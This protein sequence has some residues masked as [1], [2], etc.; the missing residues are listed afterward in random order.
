VA[1]IGQ[2]YAGCGSLV[3]TQPSNQTQNILSS[4][5][6]NTNAVNNSTFQWQMNDGSN[7]TNLSNGGQYSGVTSSQLSI[8]SLT[9]AND[10]SEFRCLITN[11]ACLD[12]T[13]V[14]TLTVECTNLIGSDPSSGV[15]YTN[16]TAQM[17]VAAANAG[18][19]FQWQNFSSGAWTNLSNG[20]QYSGVTTNTLSIANLTMANNGDSYRCVLAQAGCSDTSAAAPLTVI[21]D[22]GIEEEGVNAM[23]IYPIPAKDYFTLKV[24][25]SL[26][27]NVLIVRDL[28]GKTVLEVTI[29]AT[30]Q[31]VN[32]SGWAKGQYIATLADNGSVQMKLIVQ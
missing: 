11:G 17:I 27:N 26:L 28:S 13:N 20:G 10:N 16:S 7:W 24:D 8:N 5:L 6:F 32:I 22:I 30:E 3:F 19:D 15:A 12:T 9:L 21:S 29:T 4:A 2:L 1:E 31:N 25:P 23:S 18:A 14:A